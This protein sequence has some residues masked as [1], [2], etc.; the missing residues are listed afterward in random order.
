M[1]VKSDMSP[2]TWNTNT[3]CDKD[4]KT[5]ERTNENTDN[6]RSTEDSQSG[7]RYL[8]DEGLVEDGAQI[9]ALD[10]GLVLFLFVWQQKDFDIGV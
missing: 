3:S 4:M 9:L 2:T 10:F 1:R 5:R 6:M 8:E 7:E